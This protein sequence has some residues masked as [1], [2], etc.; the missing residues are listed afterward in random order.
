MVTVMNRTSVAAPYD[1]LVEIADKE[2]VGTD[3]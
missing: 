1:L 2:I 3:G